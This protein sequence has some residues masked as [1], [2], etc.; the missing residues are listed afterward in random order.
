MRLLI[1]AKTSA[2]GCAEHGAYVESAAHIIEQRLHLRVSRDAGW[3]FDGMVAERDV[4]HLGQRTTLGASLS[5]RAVL[6]DWKPEA[7]VLVLTLA[8]GKNVCL[9]VLSIKS[10]TPG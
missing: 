10:R 1:L 9:H 8:D 4:Y 3:R 6:F 7:A 2:V 5:L